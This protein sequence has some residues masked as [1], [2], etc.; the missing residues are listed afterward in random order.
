MQPYTPEPL[1]VTPI[2]HGAL[3]PLPAAVPSIWE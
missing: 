1:Q 2:D 3:I